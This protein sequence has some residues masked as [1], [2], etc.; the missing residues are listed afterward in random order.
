[1]YSRHESAVSLQTSPRPA[2]GQATL[3]LQQHDLDSL[4]TLH[5]HTA[6]LPPPIYELAGRSGLL[7]FLVLK[8]RNNMHTAHTL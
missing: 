7:G 4:N 5:T 3:Y 1:M 2:S 8:Y 6:L